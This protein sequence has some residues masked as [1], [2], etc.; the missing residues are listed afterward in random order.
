MKRK[1]K[2]NWKQKAGEDKGGDSRDLTRPDIKQKLEAQKDTEGEV[3]ATSNSNNLLEGENEDKLNTQKKSEGKFE[4][5]VFFNVH[6]KFRYNN[7][8]AVHTAYL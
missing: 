8:Y 4:N 1:R 5:N 2:R 7:N 6:E 3:L